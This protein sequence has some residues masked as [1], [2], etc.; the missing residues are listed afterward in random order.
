MKKHKKFI[1]LLMLIISLLTACSMEV[2]KIDDPSN[3]PEAVI[4]ATL[5]PTFTPRA[6]ATY[7]SATAIPTVEPVSGKVTAQINVREKPNASSES[8]AL[9]SINNQ[10]WIIG[11]N[12][13]ENW[14]QIYFDRQNGE[15]GEG[16]A[17]ADFILTESKPNVP[18]V[19]D[20]Y[21]FTGKEDANGLVTQ[22]INVRSGPGINFDTLGMLDKG[23]GII[24]IGKIPDGTWL[25]IE[26]EGGEKDKGWVFA[27]Y[28]D[29]NIIGSL[30]VAEGASA[31]A[32]EV[33]ATAEPIY[34]AALDDGDSMEE[35]AIMITFSA[36]D[37]RA[38]SYSSDLSYPD[39]D[40]EDWISFHPNSTNDRVDLLIDLS[41]EGNGSL[42]VELWQGG[43]QL[44]EWEEVECGDSDYPLNMYQNVT[45]QFRLLAKRSNELEY[46]NY[47]LQMRALP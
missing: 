7:I 5:Y 2:S 28:V 31:R 13:D 35:P 27:T 19:S 36:S 1:I 15:R 43:I 8:V 18:V 6:T 10:V 46:I 34:I 11:K 39:G 4:T 3:L 42:Y 26:Y 9:L 47:T 16:W 22:K 23:A 40:T 29:S 41:C 38:F 32:T 25:E 17:A 45:Y 20:G 21:Q 44:T 14:Y 33:A 37:S 12:A 30:P 24:L